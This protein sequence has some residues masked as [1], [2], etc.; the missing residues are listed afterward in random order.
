MC[1]CCDMSNTE[2]KHAYA[3]ALTH[4]H[5]HVHTHARAPA[6]TVTKK[7]HLIVN[8]VLLLMC[9]SNKLLI[10]LIVIVREQCFRSIN[11]GRSK[12]ISYNNTSKKRRKY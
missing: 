2:Y 1:H 5:T 3:R 8:R 9:T 4:A 7:Q 10:S 6:L 12:I 11:F